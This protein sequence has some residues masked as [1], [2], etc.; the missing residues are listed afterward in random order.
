MWPRAQTGPSRRSGLW[1][2]RR[3]SRLWSTIKTGCA[4]AYDAPMSW[5][6]RLDQHSV[7]V[8]AGSRQ[9]RQDPRQLTG[10]PA[11]RGADGVPARH[12]PSNGARTRYRSAFSAAA[13]GRRGNPLTSR[14]LLVLGYST[15]GGQ[16]EPLTKYCQRVRTAFRQ[17]VQRS[18]SHPCCGAN[19]SLSRPG[20]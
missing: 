7:A 17:L 18:R 5:M 2:Y 16:K 8:R 9:C 1:G 10:R 12:Q 6:I 13:K 15:A 4:P 11:G 14:F 20:P 3:V 19:L